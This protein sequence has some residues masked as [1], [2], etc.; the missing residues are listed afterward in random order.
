M[1]KNNSQKNLAI[2]LSPK[3]KSK[4]ILTNDSMKVPKNINIFRQL[5]NS[6]VI[7]GS[8]IDWILRLRNY[9]KDNKKVKTPNYTSPRFYDEDLQKYKEKIEH[10]KKIYK[11]KVNLKCN[12]E[13]YSHILN[14]RTGHPLNNSTFLYET[15]LRLRNNIKSNDLNQTPWRTLSVS[16]SESNIKFFGTYLPPML[17]NSKSN[18]EKISTMIAHPLLKSKS[19][20]NL[21]SGETI[22]ENKVNYDFNL[23]LRSPSEHFPSTRYSNNYNIKNI[24]VLRTTFENLHSPSFSHWQGD[25]REYNRNVSKVIIKSKK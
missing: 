3:A 12:L 24:N 20:V 8:D 4:P 25:L 11:N 16:P 9:K 17:K 15:T 18:L 14:N 2:Q 21:S 13:R 6:P 19:V 23:S 5:L 1:K 10:D 7:K 22:K